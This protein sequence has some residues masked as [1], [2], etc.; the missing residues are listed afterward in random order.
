LSDEVVIDGSRGEGGGQ[1]LRTGLAFSAITGKS[2]TITNIRANRPKPGLANQHLAG[3]KAIADICDAEVEGAE[4]G[5]TSVSFAPG[6]INHG[7]YE[8]AVGTAGAVTLVLQTLLPAL[9]SV[10]GESRITI[11]GGT[12]VK[13][14]PP[15]DYYR[16]VLFPLLR[17]FG[18]ECSLEVR[19]RGYYPK[20]G[21]LAESR[22]VSPR[23]LKAID[24]DREGGIDEISGTINI[25]GLPF[26][27]A[28]RIEGT[29][30]ERLPGNLSGLTR[31][32]VEHAQKG[33]SQGVGVVLAAFGSGRIL[34]GGSLGER[35]KPAESLG[36]EAA[37]NLIKEIEGGAGVDVHAAD[38][39]LPFMALAPTGSRF[40]ARALS[41]HALTNVDVI[42]RFLGKTF[43]ID[44]KAGI[45]SRV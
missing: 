40:C 2:L 39:L 36:E 23:T 21:G 20:G 6:D 24:I 32:N 27:I 17:R 19:R 35:G 7:E 14:S 13:W 3:L 5:N 26:H 18:L 43:D 11:S 41:N 37:G 1:I 31:I 12:D 28:E 34:G 42:E 8:F 30:M 29:V 25:T 9:A 44:E 38:Q 45:I 33:S 16:L 22:I 15:V 10:H 4:I